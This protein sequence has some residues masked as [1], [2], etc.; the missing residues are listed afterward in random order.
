VLLALA[1]VVI[2]VLQ[3]Q[4]SDSHV[5]NSLQS[6]T[7][8]PKLTD[9]STAVGTLPESERIQSSLTIGNGSIS[10]NPASPSS[11]PLVSQETAVAEAAQTSIPGVATTPI[12]PTVLFGDWS[13][14]DLGPVP[15]NLNRP[16]GAPIDAN[17]PQ[18]F[19]PTYVNSP[20]WVL[21]YK[22]MVFPT[23]GPIPQGPLSDS[24]DATTTQPGYVPT[25][26]VFVDATTGSP[27]GAETS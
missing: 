5:N 23:Q 21:E 24:Q 15:K 7:K 13:N 3:V 14:N 11:E 4:S 1:V 26:F 20:V 27:I 22:G 9:Y 25:L 10:I 12:Q 8:G 16:Q 6:A 19:T 17:A 2:L 18:T